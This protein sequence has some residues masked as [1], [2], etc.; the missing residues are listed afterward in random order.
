VGLG[1]TL[2]DPNVVLELAPHGLEGITQRDEHVLVRVVLGRIAT[3]GDLAAGNPHVD[4][5]AVEL[6]L[7]FVLVRRLDRDAAAYDLVRELLELRGPLAHGF[8]DRGRPIHIVELN[9]QRYLHDA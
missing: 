4:G 2:L 5:N 1:L 7:M 3:R 8:L 6:A 9:F